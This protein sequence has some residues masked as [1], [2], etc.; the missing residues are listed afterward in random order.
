MSTLSVP[1]ADEKK[2]RME[3]KEY[4]VSKELFSKTDTNYRAL[5]RQVN[6]HTEKANINRKLA[7]LTAERNALEVRRYDVDICT[8][9]LS[10]PLLG[11][12]GSTSV[13]NPQHGLC[14]SRIAPED[15][16]YV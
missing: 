12:A 16:C 14:S 7:A 1:E 6:T 4:V 3:L 8:Q 10:S 9:H 11:S 13:Q 2:L 15:F 5:Q